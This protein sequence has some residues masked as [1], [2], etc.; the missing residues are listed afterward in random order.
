VARI[1][2]D[3][4]QTWEYTRTA[5][6]TVNYMIVMGPHGLLRELRQ[7]LTDEKCAKIK[8]GMS[9]EAIRRL[10]GKPA[11]NFYFDQKKECVW[12]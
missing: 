1:D 10:L 8:P 4:M 5:E 6:G 3:G 7:V 9:K 12:D 11:H 2:A